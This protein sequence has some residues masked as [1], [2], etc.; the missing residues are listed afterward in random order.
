MQHKKYWV[1]AVIVVVFAAGGWYGYRHSGSRASFD[2]TNTNAAMT[3][4]KQFYRQ[5]SK[6]Y[7][8]LKPALDH[9]A[10]PDTYVIPGLLRT[11]TLAKGAGNRVGIS[12]T[13][14]P[15]GLAVTP[16]YVVISAYSRDK[17]YRSVMY[18]LDKHTGRLVKQLVLPGN[19]HAGGLAYD[20]VSKRLW[21]TTETASK[22]ASLSAYDASTWRSANFAQQHRATKFDHVVRMPSV[23][24]ASFITYHNNALYLGFFD[25]NAQGNFLAL[26]MTKHGLPTTTGGHNVVLR[27][28]NHPGN[29]STTKRLQGATFYHGELLFS[30][31]YGPNPA[32]LLAFDNDGQ[33]TWLD[34]DGDDTIKTVKMP[35]YME[36]IVADGEDLYVLFESGSAK[37]RKADLE[38]HADRVVKLDLGSLM[39]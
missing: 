17:K 15:Q 10:K 38:F 26:P 1:I 32:S 39:H 16:E 33:R 30:Q 28:D 27:G 3:T 11:K 24:R 21:V 23:K 14:D 12:K 9:D 19:S 18:F 36:Q 37:Y 31:S 22:V 5:L 29:Y 8:Q 34:F 13:M 35:P 20:T 4:Q 6:Q 7:P 25:R 2:G